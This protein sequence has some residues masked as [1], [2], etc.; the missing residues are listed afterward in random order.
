[1]EMLLAPAHRRDDGRAPAP[2]AAQTIMRDEDCVEFLQ[3]CLP[4]LN[5][6]W[7]GY[8]KVRRTVC[9]RARRRLREIGLSDLESYRAYLRDHSE[10]WARLDAFC[11]ISISQFYR[12]RSVFDDLSRR[13]LPELAAAASNRDAR[14]LRC[15]CAGCASGEEVYTL[16]IIWDLSVRP[17]HPGVGFEILGTDAE[18][19]L[20]ARAEAA[21]YPRGALK[22]LPA[23]YL[24]AA[25][26][27][28]SEAFSLRSEFRRDVTFRLEDIRRAQPDGPFDLILCRNLAFTYFAAEQQTAILGS[29][30]ARLAAGGYLAIGAHEQLPAGAGDLFQAT[31]KLPVYRE[32]APRV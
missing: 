32:S 6:R 21:R 2:G 12:D 3:W 8:R 18:A 16:R 26:T 23:A 10:E 7:S 22:D 14:T 29:I 17:L 19:T 1:M 4:R 11:R 24:E 25:F 13:V 5:L 31:P 27:Q 9:K 15:W 30:A 20:L 28:D